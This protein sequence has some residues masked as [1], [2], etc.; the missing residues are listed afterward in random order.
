MEFISKSVIDLYSKLLLNVSAF[1]LEMSVS[2]VNW[3]LDTGNRALQCI[4]FL[5]NC[6]YRYFP[7]P[8]V[9][10]PFKWIIEL[11]FLYI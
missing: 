11:L 1:V 4:L 3:G 7:F 10:F 9:F 8:S 5:H 2:V 6:L